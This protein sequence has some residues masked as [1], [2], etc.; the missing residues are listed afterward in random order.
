MIDMVY[1][2]VR[3]KDCFDGKIAVDLEFSGY[4]TYAAAKVR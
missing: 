4:R 3:S 2:Y 1:I